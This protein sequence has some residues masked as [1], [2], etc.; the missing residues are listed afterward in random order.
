MNVYSPVTTDGIPN[1]HAIRRK[2][3]EILAISIVVFLFILTFS[4]LAWYFYANPRIDPS[5]CGERLAGYYRGW[6]G[7]KVSD[8]QLEKLTHVIYSSAVMDTNGNVTFGNKEELFMELQNKSRSVNPDL[9]VLVAIGSGSYKSVD[10]MVETEKNETFIHSITSFISKYDIDGVELQWKHYPGSVASKQLQLIRNLRAAL[11]NLADSQNRTSPYVLAV[12]LP[13]TEWPSNNGVSLDHLLEHVDFV[14]VASF[15]YSISPGPFAPLYSTNHTK[16]KHFSKD[17]K[18]VDYTLKS[19]ACQTKQWS[20]I[21]MGVG[22]YGRSWKN[23]LEPDQ[24]RNELAWTSG[25]MD[26]KGDTVQW[27]NLKNQQKED[28]ESVNPHIWDSENKEYISFENERSLAEK[29]KYAVEKNLGGITISMLDFDDD[30]DTLLNAVASVDLCK[31]YVERKNR[32]E[33]RCE[34]IFVDI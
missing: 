4:A 3:N 22:F 2:R 20:K 34:D 6:G 21:N 16:D 11:I 13:S 15:D 25:S 1:L 10:F 14:N 17:T 28:S 29:A 5:H 23:V 33:Y 24:V 8:S 12:S 31:G 18:N 32:M 26:I 9:K 19:Q 27:R 7:R 30:N